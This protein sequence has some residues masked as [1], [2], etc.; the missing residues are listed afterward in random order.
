MNICFGEN[1][2]ELRLKANMTQERLADYIGVSFQSISKWER[3]DTYP[4]ITILPEIASFFNVSVDSLLGVNKA[5][6]EQE[7]LD[8]IEKYDNLSDNAQKEKQILEMYE[9]YPSDFRIQL[10]Y[11]GYLMFLSVRD[12]K[13]YLPKIQSIY[14]NIQA[15]CTVDSIRICAKRYLAV[16]YCE[17]SH[18]EDS[19][20]TVADSEKIIAEMPHMR[21]GQ[22]FISSY[23]YDYDD[24]VCTEKI[25][26][27]MDEEISLLIHGISHHV[28]GYTDERISLDYR[29][30]VAEIVIHLINTFYNDYNYGS[31]W[32][33]LIYIHGKLGQMYFQKGD[34][35]SAVQNLKKAAELTKR[36]DNMDRFTT[37]HSSFFEGRQFDKH[38]LG[39]TINAS[40]N[41]KNL[42]TQV[43]ALSEEFRS[44]KE[45]QDI[46]EYLDES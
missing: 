34:K 19:G 22:E 9:K 33:D 21:D 10:R 32:L 45:F 31:E 18:I 24:P 41:L 43:Y 6:N 20:I 46:I 5:E 44:S 3:G 13:K 42:M 11:L 39:S 35:E 37:L 36:F 15:N 28:H 38:I 12:Y 40:S 2:K 27:A 30:K 4:D 8:F 16:H 29:I 23:I 17:L 1:L 7:I 26:E 25:Q 14:N